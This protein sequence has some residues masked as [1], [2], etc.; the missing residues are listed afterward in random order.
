MYSIQNG[1]LSI[2][3]ILD[4]SGSAESTEQIMSPSPK[5]QR[6]SGSKK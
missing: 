1:P 6:P 2:T 3:V 5:L 4:I